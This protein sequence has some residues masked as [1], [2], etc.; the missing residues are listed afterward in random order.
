M[1]LIARQKI[2]LA[3][4]IM[5]NL[6]L[7][8]IPSDVVE[9][10]AR[11]RHVMLGRYSRTHF[12]WNVGVLVIS[13]ISFYVDWSTG[14]TYKKRWFQVVASLIFFLPVLAVVDYLIRTPAGEHYV[15][16]RVAYHR[17]VEA[18]F[19]AVFEDRPEARRTYPGAPAGFGRVDCTLTTD[20]RGYRNQTAR[21]QYDVVVLGDSFAEGSS[22]S[23]EHVWPVHLA[24]NT[25]LS[26]YNLGMSG[27]DPFHYLESLKEYGLALKPRYVVCLLYE[28]NDFRSAKS[29]R[30]RRNP[31]FSKRLKEYLKRSPI[32]NGLD[33]LLI[34]TFGPINCTGQVPGAE[35]LDWLPLIIPE[36]VAG[37]PYAFA[38]KQ[39]RDLYGSGEEF[40]LDKHW[41]NPR[42][43]LAGID[44][45][46]QQAGCRL[47]VAFAPL[48]AHVTLPVVADRLDAEK[49][50]AFLKLR[51]K[52]ELPE[53]ETFLANLLERVDAR[54]EVVAEW[55]RRESIPFLSVTEALREAAVAGTQVYYTYDQHW[56]PDGHAVVA[57]SVARFLAE[58]LP[59]ANGAAASEE[60][61]SY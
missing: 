19:H 29:D 6:G 12:S 40:A 15:R 30:K 58:G 28:G 10:I 42:R 49:V 32:I 22:V 37:K 11:D 53:A 4:V 18:E 57:E 56:T 55:C 31:S 54:E 3:I 38:P 25:G 59:D 1:K 45:Q 20:R 46:C 39:L 43:Q 9:Q 14:E 2:W 17:P 61:T 48:K 13:L 5:V 24:Q 44:E 16:D 34:N 35:I 41:L 8:I 27:Y 7:W 51:Y 26:V 52:K 23:D 60:T 21:D 47:I 36:G 50:R 33:N